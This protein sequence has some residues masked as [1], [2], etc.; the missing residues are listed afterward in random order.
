MTYDGRNYFAE[1]VGIFVLIFV[2]LAVLFCFYYKIGIFLVLGLLFYF[3]FFMY[4]D[5]KM[6]KEDLNSMLS[7]KKSRVV[8]NRTLPSE[9]P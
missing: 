2:I 8:Y 9:I 1:V 7:P 5:K 3:M 6:K 4:K